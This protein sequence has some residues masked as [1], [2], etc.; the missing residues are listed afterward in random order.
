MNVLILANHFN[1][2]GISRYVLN[3]SHGLKER[4][5]NIWVASSGGEWVNRLTPG[6][7]HETIPIKT[8]A[9]LSPKVFFSF[10]KLSKFVKNNNIQIVHANT[11]VTAAVAQLL[12]KFNRIPYITAFHGYYRPGLWRKL[13]KLSGMRSIAVSHAVENHL[14]VDLKIDQPKIRVVYNGIELEDF[15]GKRAQ[16]GDFGFATKDLLF[17]ILGRISQEK[18]HFLA[19]AA[20]EKILQKHPSSYLLLSGKGKME[21]KLKLFIEERKIASRVKFIDCEAGDFLDILDILL[22]P[23]VKEGFGLS[24]VEAFAKRVPVIGFNV[25]GISEIIRNSENGIIFYEYTADA[26]A[27]AVENLLNNTALRDKI[28]DCASRDVAAFS[29]SAMAGRTEAVYREVLS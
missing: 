19:A 20:F 9:I 7:K 21:Q 25:G 18:G 12:F 1:P 14:A 17:G 8:K 16:R 27:S 28:I 3:L 2:G 22:V 5:N 23:S 4:G 24:I 10:V 11:R 29:L 6:V 15:T 13:I 26:L